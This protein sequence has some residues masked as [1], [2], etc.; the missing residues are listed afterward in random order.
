M[1]AREI[2]PLRGGG[3]LRTAK[4]PLAGDFRSALERDEK[5]KLAAAPV[6]MTPLFWLATET[7]AY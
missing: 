1:T 3:D 5:Q 7:V 4:A 2:P 6:G